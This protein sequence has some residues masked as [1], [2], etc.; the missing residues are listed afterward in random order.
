MLKFVFSRPKMNRWKI[1]S[2]WKRMKTKN[3]LKYVISSWGAN[4][5][6]AFISHLHFSTFISAIQHFNLIYIC[7]FYK[8]QS[9]NSG[10]IVLEI[11]REVFVALHINHRVVVIYTRHCWPASRWGFVNWKSVTSFSHLKES[12]I[13][14]WQI[15]ENSSI[16][17]LN[18]NFPVMSSINFWKTHP[19]LIVGL[20]E[21]SRKPQF[22]CPKIL[23]SA[24]EWVKLIEFSKNRLA[25]AREFS[26]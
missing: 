9:L 2:I 10:V 7:H 24:I 6:C 15:L 4:N 11:V 20:D 17:S 8:I 13:P 14:Y 22:S 23:R 5:F 3:L 16:F 26:Q 25:H 18:F 21:F 1:S 19:A 12:V